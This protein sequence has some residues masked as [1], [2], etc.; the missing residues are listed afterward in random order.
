MPTSTQGKY[1]FA[2]DF[3]KIG[4][5]C[6]GDVGIAPYAVFGGIMQNRTHQALCLQLLL[7]GQAAVFVGRVAC[8]LAQDLDF[9]QQLRRF[10]FPRG[11]QPA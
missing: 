7:S 6:R 10:P 4:F 2:G 5:I 1:E 3:R 11:A 9:R 8:D